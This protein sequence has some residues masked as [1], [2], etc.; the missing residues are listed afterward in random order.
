MVVEKS[1]YA[2]KICV[3][4]DFSSELGRNTENASAYTRDTRMG[5]SFSCGSRR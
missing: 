5:T 2:R 1:E 3:V 4:M